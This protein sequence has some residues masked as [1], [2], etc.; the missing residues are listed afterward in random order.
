MVKEKFRKR[1]SNR[2]RALPPC[3]IMLLVDLHLHESPPFVVD[4]RDH[5]P[6]IVEKRVKLYAPITRTRQ[7]FNEEGF[8]VGCTYL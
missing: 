3:L 7:T 4:A 6:F 1:D 5:V 2:R 8:L